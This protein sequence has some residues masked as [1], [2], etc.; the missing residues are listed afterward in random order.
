MDDN[1]N[2]ESNSTSGSAQAGVGQKR[3][4]TL[5]RNGGRIANG[6]DFWSRVDAWFSDEIAKRDNDLSGP[7]WKP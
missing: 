6:D 7:L 1:L 4:R 3:K 2:E 5:A